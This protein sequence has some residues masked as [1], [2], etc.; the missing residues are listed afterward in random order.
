MN[1]KLAGNIYANGGMTQ[2]DLYDFLFNEDDK[3]DAPATAPSEEEVKTVQQPQQDQSQSDS[4]YD[5]TMQMAMQIGMFEGHDDPF[6]NQKQYQSTPHGVE[7]P[8]GASNSGF[9]SYSS[10]EEGRA[11]LLHQLDLYRTG[12]THNPVG[13]NSSILQAM[14]VYAPAKDH[15]DPTHYANV[16]ANH[17]GVSPHTPISQIDPNKWADAITKMEGN[18]K[19]NNP[20]NLRK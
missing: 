11:A 9:K 16:V 17:L 20:G 12:K 10:P 7:A 14:S 6:Y 1:K 18:K 4:E 19:G 2:N 3:E 15:N 13:P 8:G 5:N